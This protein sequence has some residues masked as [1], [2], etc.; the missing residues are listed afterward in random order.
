[1]NSI[2]IP[3]YGKLKEIA[4]N[5]DDLTIINKKI[6]RFFLDEAIDFSDYKNDSL[7]KLIISDFFTNVFIVIFVSI[8]IGVPAYFGWE[9]IAGIIGVLVL[10][11]FL[12]KFFKQIIGLVIILFITGFIGGLLGIDT[13]SN[14]SFL[15]AIFCIGAFRI[16]TVINRKKMV[17]DFYK[18]EAAIED[19]KMAIIDIAHEELIP[20]AHQITLATVDSLRDTTDTLF[21]DEDLVSDV[22]NDEYLKGYFEVIES[23]GQNEQ[24]IYKSILNNIPS[25]EHMETFELQL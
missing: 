19:H 8:I 16:Y 18:N 24:K 3:S 20:V 7:G 14:Y 21:L 4:K 15:V 22:L 11:G 6:K 23:V 17:D 13:A 25:S 2:I 10:L 9:V 12:I 5:K 1:M